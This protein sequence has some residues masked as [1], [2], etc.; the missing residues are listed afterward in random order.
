ME[1]RNQISVNRLFLG[2]ILLQIVGGSLLSRFF[3]EQLENLY[4]NL[5]FA[6][7]LLWFP[8][9]LYGVLR[10][11][12]LLKG[13]S[14]EK[15]SWKVYPLVILLGISLLPLLSLLNLLSTQ[16]AGS[17]VSG[18]LDQLSQGELGLNLLFM[19]VMPAV[20]EELAFR[21]FLY[22][23]YQKSAPWKGVLFSALC[24]GLMHLNL[25]Q[26]S[27]A[28]VIGIAA[29][30]LVYI[31]NSLYP[32]IL[33]HFF[34]NGNSVLLQFWVSKMETVSGLSTTQE[35]IDVSGAALLI[36]VLV[37]AVLA[38]VGVGISALLYWAIVKNCSGEERMRKFFKPSGSRPVRV[39]SL[40]YLAA[41]VLAVGYMIWLI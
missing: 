22:S 40:S 14:H 29:A 8:I 17:Q 31:T 25:N 39:V 2:M 12:N 6:Q 26:F 41:V 4:V 28:F 32:A 36:L 33:L 30:L 23:A 20:S 35:S 9:T 34:Y 16:V 10:G 24:F 7:V 5:I 15:V 1:R 13:I 19:A 27:Y 3:S 18:L 37:L 11:N 21:G 38:L